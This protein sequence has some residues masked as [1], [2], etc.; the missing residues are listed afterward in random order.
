M[1]VEERMGIGDVGTAT[2]YC[3]RLVVCFSGGEGS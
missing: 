2:R 3:G 1:M